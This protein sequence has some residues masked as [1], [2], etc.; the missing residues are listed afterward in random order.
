MKQAVV[1]AALQL[2]NIIIRNEGPAKIL[3]VP[4]EVRAD[5]N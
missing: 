5:N 2:N 3:H 1:I 4:A